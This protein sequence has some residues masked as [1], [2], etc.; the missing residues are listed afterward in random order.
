MTGVQTCALPILSASAALARSLRADAATLA[1]RF[2]MPPP[3]RADAMADAFVAAVSSHTRIAIVDHIAAEAAVILPLADIARR[4]KARGVAVLADGAHAPG[5]VALDVPALGVDWYVANLHKSAF[6][7]RSS[8]FLWAA[9]DRQTGLHPTV[10]SWGLDEGFTKEFDSV[11]TRDASAHLAAPAA[12]AFIDSFGLEAILAH[13]HALAWN[14]ARMLA[15]TWGTSFDTPEA[16]I[17]TMASV[18]LPES[19]GTSRDDAARLRDALLFEDQI[20]VGV[21]DRKSVV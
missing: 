4:V 14:G 18:P 8:G 13:N 5:A 3:L 1:A 10:I 11:G 2:M 16:L 17:G 20:E 6:V 19:L 12:L 15:Q 7:P 9:P 21:R